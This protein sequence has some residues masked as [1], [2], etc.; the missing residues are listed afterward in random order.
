VLT[1]RDNEHDSEQSVGD[2][3]VVLTGVAEG[4]TARE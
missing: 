2:D 4:V 3:E 1:V